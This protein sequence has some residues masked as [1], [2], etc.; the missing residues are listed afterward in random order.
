MA[1]SRAN[2]MRRG[3]CDVSRFD[4]RRVLCK[5]HR[6]YCVK[7]TRARFIKKPV[8]SV[9]NSFQQ[10]HQGQS[11]VAAVAVE[12]FKTGIPAPHITKEKSRFRPKDVNTATLIFCQKMDTP[13]IAQ[14][15]V[16]GTK[17]KKKPLTGF[18][19]TTEKTKTVFC[20]RSVN[21]ESARLTRL[22]AT[23]KELRQCLT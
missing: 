19:L 13:L 12:F 16:S 1:G 20:V 10:K 9:A 11:P 6:P 8:Q 18:T 14:N 7:P 5:Q 2:N 4:T 17:T 23:N 21:T 3:L 15:S 22:K